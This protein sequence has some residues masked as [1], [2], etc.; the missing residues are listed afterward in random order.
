MYCNHCK[1]DMYAPA[2]YVE[3]LNNVGDDKMN[4]FVPE[5]LKTHGITSPIVTFAGLTESKKVNKRRRGA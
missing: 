5:H 2:S 4:K 3:P 1:R